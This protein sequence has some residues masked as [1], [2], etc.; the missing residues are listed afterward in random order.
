MMTFNTRYGTSVIRL[1]FGA[2]LLTAVSNREVAADSPRLES[3]TLEN[4]DPNGVIEWTR[5][6]Y[7]NGKWNA[8]PDIA[9]WR[10]NYYV[11]INK[12][13][14]HNGL[15]GPGIVLRSS[16]LKYWELIY[17]TTGSP[18][19]GS[20]VDCKLLALPD[21]LVLYYVYMRREVDPR[22]PLGEQKPDARNYAE[23]RAVYTEDGRNWS[24]SQRIYE[25][26]HNFWKPKV[27]DGVIYVASDYVDAGRTEYITAAEERNPKLFR[28]D[29]LRSTDGI[30]W[31]KVSTILEDAPWSVTETAL[32]FRPDGE[33]WAFTRQDFLSRSR[34]PYKDWTS[35]RAHIV[36]GGIAGP[37]MIAVGDDVYLAGRFYAYL[38]KHGPADSPQTNKFATSL[39]KYHRAAGRFESIADLPMPSYADLG[40]SGFVK[41][42]EGVFVVYYSGH[43]YREANLARGNYS[44][45]TDVYLSKLKISTPAPR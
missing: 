3:P 20:A 21:R 1:V 29:L 26:G 33:L 18:E 40:Y 30:K 24:G 25:P 15:D 16:N 2:I 27:R 41:T 14:I 36:G 8:T 9:H 13:T 22:N 34:P 32:A 23:T 44:T 37:E 6:I 45:Q 12:G 10:G 7:S 31:R 4:S 19:N 11:C 42:R 17:T 5:K 28:I 35:K 43:A 38:A 39:L